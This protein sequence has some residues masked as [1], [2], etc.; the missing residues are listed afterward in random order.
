MV[1]GEIALPAALASEELRRLESAAPGLEKEARDYL[2]A[3]KTEV[4]ISC[5]EVSVVQYE[6]AT[7]DPGSSVPYR[8]T[9]PGIDA[10]FIRSLY[11]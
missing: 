3:H 1:L 11:E 10:G 4:A 2:A 7:L 5:D 9:A 8:I 6:N